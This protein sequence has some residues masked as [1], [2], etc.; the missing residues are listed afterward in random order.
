MATLYGTLL[1]PMSPAECRVTPRCTVEA[2]EDGRIVEVAGGRPRPAGALGDEG[3]W[4][5]PGFVD[6]HLHVAQWDRR[7]IDG[8]PLFRWQEKVGFPAEMRMSDAA[9]AEGMAEQFTAGVIARGTTCVVGFGT[10]FAAE[11]EA[12]FG[13]FARRGLRATYGMSLNDVGVPE[14]MAQSADEALDQSRELAA[15]WHGA[16][17]G[18]TPRGAPSQRNGGA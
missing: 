4:I 10:P 11:V 9:A 7:G 12:T 18:D 13:V 15:R 14:G 16:E 1:Q 5:L 3:S 6:A 17:G 8:M 2:G